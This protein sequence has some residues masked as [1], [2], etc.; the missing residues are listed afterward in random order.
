MDDNNSEIQAQAGAGRQY[1]GYGNYGGYGGFVECCEGVVDPLLL[2]SIILGEKIRVSIDQ[3]S[4]PPNTENLLFRW[5][6]ERVTKIDIF[7]NLA[8]FL[9]S[10]SEIIPRVVWAPPVMN[11]AH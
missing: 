11:G 2:L 4:F 6:M 8:S 9:S 7:H 10:S 1:G 3:N 5:R